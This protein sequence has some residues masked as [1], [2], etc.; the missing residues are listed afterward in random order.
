MKCN[1]LVIF[2]FFLF[3][4]SGCSN[5][6]QKPIIIAGATFPKPL[7]E[8]MFNEYHKKTGIKVN[9]HAIGSGGGIFK[10]L[11]NEVD[12]G[13]TDILVSEKEEKDY[14]TEIVHI[15]ICLG[16][17]VITYNLPA[18]PEL[19]F[20]PKILADIFLGK[21]K[22]W[23]HPKIKEINPEIIL[24]NQR[25]MLVRRSDKSGTSNIF[26]DFLSKK[27]EKWKKKVEKNNLL[28][29]V[30]GFGAK[31][32]QDVIEI[33]SETPGAIGYVSMNY[34]LTNNQPVAKIRNS[35]GKFIKPTVESVKISSDMELPE[36]AEIYLTD[37]KAKNGYPIS[38]FTWIISHHDLGFPKDKKKAQDLID[39]LGWMI[40]EGQK[41]AEPLHYSPLSEKAII[42]AENNIRKI[43]KITHS[44]HYFM[45]KS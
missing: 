2:I 13:A 24:P 16:A 29:F 1:K 9:Y 17:V 10:L 22:N 36:D 7:Y 39:L 42:N 33:I 27:S 5:K 44:N 34:A 12:L 20:T 35:S 32:N 11:N 3:F 30:L 6:K 15:P 31:S 8:K 19:N 37:T 18:N 21:I 40:H 43:K 26:S 14:Q 28:E 45:E 38:S 23:N 41:Y 25:I 4:V